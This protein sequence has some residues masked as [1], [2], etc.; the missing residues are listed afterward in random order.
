M[1]KLILQSIDG[2]NYTSP[3]ESEN[4]KGNSAVVIDGDWWT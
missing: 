3:L 1:Q 2:R 4:G